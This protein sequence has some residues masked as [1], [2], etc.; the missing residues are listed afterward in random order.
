VPNASRSSLLYLDSSALVK[1]VVAEPES[2]ALFEF[3]AGW[4]H[5]VSSSLARVEVLRA[6]KRTGAGSAVRRRA[7]RVLARVALVRIDSPVLAA[8]VRVAPPELRTLDALHLA[9]AR[10]L[11]DLAGIVTYDARL[12]RAATRARV[13]VWSPS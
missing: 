8:A 12:G 4:P 2:S 10:S 5:R 11:D 6:V 13:K 7:A 3:L 9:T 1:L